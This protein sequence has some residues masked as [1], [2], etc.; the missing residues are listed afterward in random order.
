MSKRTIL[1]VDMAA[2]DDCQEYAQSALLAKWQEKYGD[3][4]FVRRELRHNDIVSIEYS[5]DA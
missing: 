1:A 2:S 3:H 5:F 4:P